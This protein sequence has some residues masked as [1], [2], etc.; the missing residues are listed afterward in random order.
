[1]WGPHLEKFLPTPLS[2][3]TDGPAEREAE[4]PAPAERIA[5]PQVG[6]V[7][8]RVRNRMRDRVQEDSGMSSGS[9]QFRRIKAK[10]MVKVY[11]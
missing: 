4:P 11:L 2:S 8:R 5:A 7:R 9:I 3:F 6:G 1:M 10:P